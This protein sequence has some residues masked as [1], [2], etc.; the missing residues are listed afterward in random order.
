LLPPFNFQAVAGG[1]NE[2]GLTVTFTPELPFS[3]TVVNMA[4]A[5]GHKPLLQ[6]VLAAH[7]KAV[8]WFHDDKNRAEAVAMMV[9]ASRLK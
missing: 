7:G 1:F 2:L 4:W 6:R 8:A 9:E 5:T 3:G